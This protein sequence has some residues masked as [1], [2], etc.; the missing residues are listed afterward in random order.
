MKEVCILGIGIGIGM[1]IMSLKHRNAEKEKH[2]I[3][4]LRK[5]WEAE[6]AAAEGAAA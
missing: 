4:K 1:Y 5:Q 2:L 3:S 6:R